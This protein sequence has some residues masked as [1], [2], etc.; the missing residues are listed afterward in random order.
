M[1][2]RQPGKL[3]EWVS[4]V[5]TAYQRFRTNLPWPSGVCIIARSARTHSRETTRS[6]Q[7]FNGSVTLWQESERD[8]RSQSWREVVDDDAYVLQ[9]FE[10]HALSVTNQSRATPESGPEKSYSFGK[11]RG[12]PAMV[13]SARQAFIARFK[14]ANEFERGCP[15]RLG[16]RRA[17]CLRNP[18][19]SRQSGV[20][21]FVLRTMA[22][23]PRS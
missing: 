21:G 13:R 7:T 6:T 5:W 10:A 2:R 4:Y 3:G 11:L 17:S 18:L 9:A 14:K 15:E 1:P 22:D 16:G 19:I 23:C 12:Q 20:R 8:R